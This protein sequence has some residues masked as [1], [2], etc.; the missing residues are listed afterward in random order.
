MARK[1]Q[2]AN[3]SSNLLHRVPKIKWESLWL[4]C[5]WIKLRKK[6]KGVIIIEIH[7]NFNKLKFNYNNSSNCR[8]INNCNNR[9]NN[10]FNI[11]FKTNSISN[12]S[13][14]YSNSNSSNN[15]FRCNS[16][17]SSSNT[18]SS[19]N[20]NTYKKPFNCNNKKHFLLKLNGVVNQMITHLKI[21]II[22]W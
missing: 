4:H 13:N 2:S 18:S 3:K 12:N 20:N 21:T 8:L 22:T 17:C 11:S 10:K 16:K 14:L 5:K 15:Y 19:C 6:C 9:I 1:V 7:S